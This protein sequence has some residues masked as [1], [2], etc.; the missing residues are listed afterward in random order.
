MMKEQ[1]NLRQRYKK[2]M[3]FPANRIGLVSIDFRRRFTQG[4]RMLTP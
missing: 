3:N 4:F 2:A 1:N